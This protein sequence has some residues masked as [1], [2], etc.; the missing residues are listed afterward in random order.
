MEVAVHLNFPALKCLAE[1]LLDGVALWKQLWAWIGILPIQVMARE[2]ASV[3]PYD[4]AVGV[5][6]R[7]NL[8]NVPFSQSLC[9][10]FV[11]YQV[12]NKSFHHE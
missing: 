11:A 9:R 3:V 10:L 7:H 8:E 4:D 6:H 12:L 1:H 2:A 5:E